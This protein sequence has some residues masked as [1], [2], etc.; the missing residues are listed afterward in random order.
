MKYWQ[1]DSSDDS[2]KTDQGIW[3]PPYHRA[4]SVDVEMTAYGLLTY[5]LKRDF[6]GG[7]PIAKWIV[8]QRNSRGGFASTQ[9]NDTSVFSAA[10]VGMVVVLASISRCLKTAFVAFCGI[11]QAVQL[12]W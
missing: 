8:S 7:V 5:V 10:Y 9:V 4:R 2:S 3:R 1:K 12:Y 11:S 6:S